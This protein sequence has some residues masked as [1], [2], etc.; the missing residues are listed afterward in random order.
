MVSRPI[1]QIVRRPGI[2]E[3]GWGHPDPALLPVQALRLA[4][5]AALDQF[6]ADALQYGHAAGPGPLLEW[7]AERIGRQEG[8]RPGPDEIMTTGGISLG[9]DALLTALTAAGDTVLVESPTYHLALRILRDHALNLVP[10]PADDDGLRVDAL[11]SILAHQR[12]SGQPARALYLV[13]TFNNPTGRSLSDGR[14]RALVALA[15][16][17]DLL[18]IEMT[19]IASWP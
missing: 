9:L 3:L 11:T 15:A 6:G 12:N 13:L 16:T 4:S 2:I 8:R 14:R 17:E 1:L 5:A 10:V 7:L 18:I 19:S